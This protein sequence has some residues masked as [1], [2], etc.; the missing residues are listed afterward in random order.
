MKLRY[1]IVT[2]LILF[3]YVGIISQELTSWRNVMVCFLAGSWLKM[4][5]IIAEEI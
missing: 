1:K 2:F 4:F 5:F 3:F